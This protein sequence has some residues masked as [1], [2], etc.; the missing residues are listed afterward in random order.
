MSKNTN[1]SSDLDLSTQGIV[2]AL[3]TGRLGAAASFASCYFPCSAP[4]GCLF[5]LLIFIGMAYF[6]TCLLFVLK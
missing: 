5:G 3:D 4:S 1:K 2:S 6:A